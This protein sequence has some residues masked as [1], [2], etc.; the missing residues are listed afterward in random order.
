MEDGD[1]ETLV[2]AL[3]LGLRRSPPVGD[4]A[5][6][7]PKMPVAPFPSSQ[8]YH[9][10]RQEPRLSSH[11][12]NMM[13][14]LDAA[15]SIADEVALE[16]HMRPHLLNSQISVGSIYSTQSADDDDTEPRQ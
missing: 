15:L 12:T 4:A 11:R 3:A 13:N 6:H 9:D 10:M 16:H 1:R 5:H 14:I 8:L 7:L 2:H